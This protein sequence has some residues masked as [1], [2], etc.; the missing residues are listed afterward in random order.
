[1]V[2]EVRQTEPG[3]APPKRSIDLAVAA[4]EIEHREG[5]LTVAAHNIGNRDAGPF[6]MTVWE[7]DPGAGKGLEEFKID[8]LPAPNDLKPSRITRTVEW[9]PPRHASLDRPV[10]ITVELAPDGRPYEITESNN[11][12]VQVFPREP[13]TYRVPRMW[14]TLAREHGLQPGD[15]YPADFPRD[16]RH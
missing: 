16:Q 13:E 4:A 2:V 12:A 8:G 7:G 5:R 14:K 11:R 6:R 3:Q 1:M 10:K 9:N 15:P